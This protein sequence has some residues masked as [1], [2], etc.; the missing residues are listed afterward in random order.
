MLVSRDLD[1]I[2]DSETMT[3]NTTFHY[4][5]ENSGDDQHGNKLTIV[6]CHG[7]LVAEN[8]GEIKE[9][10]NPDFS[11]ALARDRKSG[12]TRPESRLEDGVEKW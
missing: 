10:V 7:K 9:L 6:K 4:E 8:S 2:G 11:Q 12:M 1:V 5:V 3:A